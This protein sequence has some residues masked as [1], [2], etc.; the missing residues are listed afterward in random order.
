MTLKSLFN[1]QCPLDL[2]ADLSFQSLTKYMNGHEDVI[3][4]AVSTNAPKLAEKL[5]WIQRT[6][7]AIPRYSKLECE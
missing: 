1:L 5:R 7:G 2:G 4:G 3:M 6:A